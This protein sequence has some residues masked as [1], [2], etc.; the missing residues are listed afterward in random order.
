MSAAHDNESDP[1][2]NVPLVVR[3][4]A[5]AAEGRK[6]KPEGAMKDADSEDDDDDD[7]DDAEEEED[8]DSEEEAEGKKR[9]RV[10]GMFRAHSKRLHQPCCVAYSAWHTH[11]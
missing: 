3:Q 11:I 1:E 10:S 8:A 2:S 7:D 9:K 5:L 4:N 6:R